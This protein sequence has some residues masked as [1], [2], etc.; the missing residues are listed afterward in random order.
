MQTAV[1]PLEN[2]FPEA[3]FGKFLLIQKKTVN[4]PSRL[5]HLK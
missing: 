1:R 5:T 2:D 3:T 4:I